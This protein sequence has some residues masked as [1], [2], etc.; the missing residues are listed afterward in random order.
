LEAGAWC[1][2]RVLLLCVKQV[3][4]PRAGVRSLLRPNEPGLQCERHEEAIQSDDQ[5]CNES[6]HG[7]GEFP[8][9]E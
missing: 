4:S 2:A 8:V 3:S 9:Y 6:T 7:A 1:P 5:E